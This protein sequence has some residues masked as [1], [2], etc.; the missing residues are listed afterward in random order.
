MEVLTA[1][2]KQRQFAHELL[3]LGTPVLLVQEIDL[4]NIRGILDDPTQLTLIRGCFL[5]THVNPH[6]V[7]T[8]LLVHDTAV[9][10]TAI[11]RFPPNHV[12]S[13]LFQLTDHDGTGDGLIAVIK[14]HIRQIPVATILIQHR[15]TQTVAAAPRGIHHRR[16]PV[17][18]AVRVNTVVIPQFVSREQQTFPDVGIT[19]VLRHPGRV[20]DAGFHIPV[21]IRIETQI[22][23]V[24]KITLALLIQRRDHPEPISWIIPILLLD[25][26]QRVSHVPSCADHQLH[27]AQLLTVFQLVQVSV[28]LILQTNRVQR[29]LQVLDQVIAVQYTTRADFNSTGQRTGDRTTGHGREALLTLQIDG[30]VLR[31]V[32]HQFHTRENFLPCVLRV[33][34]DN[35]QQFP[36]ETVRQL[37]GVTGHN[38][39]HRRAIT[40]NEGHKENTESG[41]AHTGRERDTEEI[42]F[43]VVEILQVIH[44][45]FQHQP[46]R[47]IKPLLGGSIPLQSDAV[48]IEIATLTGE[49]VGF[50]HQLQTLSRSDLRRFLTQPS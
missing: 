18:I 29:F 5:V 17:G 45:R 35:G 32:V 14:H 19:H 27:R 33:I 47:Q 28:V 1:D 24:V 48:T 26:T 44:Q 49:E 12:G 9:L 39:C 7:L 22:V 25:A 30:L 41:L 11:I 31:A 4:L 36:V 15:H 16:D 13:V 42:Q 40:H 20:I 8:Q 43:T 34:R 6:P 50:P 2:C 38:V 10:V 23:L 37:V 21:V 3:V 46:A